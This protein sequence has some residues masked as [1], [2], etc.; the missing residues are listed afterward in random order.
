MGGPHQPDG[1]SEPAPSARDP[2]DHAVDAGAGRS[3]AARR[4]VFALAALI[5]GVVLAR[6]VRVEPA[7]AWFAGSCALAALAGA[8]RGGVCRVALLIATVLFGAG[9]FTHRVHEWS[10]ATL[11]V[12]LAGDEG[13]PRGSLA[14]GRLVTLEGVIVESARESAG[15]SGALAQFAW[16]EHELT[17]PL[18]V[19]RVMGRSASERVRG[20]VR[21]GVR[22]RELDGVGVGDRVRV[23]G[24]FRP[25]RPPMNPGEPARHLWAAQR[26]EAGWVDVPDARLIERVD[27]EPG[28]GAWM[29]RAWRRARGAARARAEGVLAG[30]ERGDALMRALVLGRRDPALEPT[31]EAFVR[32]GVAHLMAISGFHLAVMAGAAMAL[33]RVTGDRGR[34]EPVL[35]GAILL[36]YLLIVPSRAP[37]VRAGVMVLALLAGESAGRRH[38]R[39][40]L[41]AWIAA[42]LAVAR[43]MDVFTLGYQLSMGLTGVLLWAAPSALARLGGPAIRGLRPAASGFSGRNHPARIAGRGVASA[44]LVALICWTVS[45]PVIASHTGRVALLA[46]PATLIL[47]PLV[48]V[49]L[50]GGYAALLVGVMV[51]A[52]GRAASGVAGGLGEGVVESVHWMDGFAWSWVTLPRLSVA[53]AIAGSALTLAWWRFGRVRSVRWWGAGVVVAAWLGAHLV[54]VPGVNRQTLLRLDTLAVGD[55]SC[56]LIRSGDDAALFDCGSRW[57]GLGERVVP[58]AVRALGA[59]RVR[60]IVLSHPNLDHFSGV[61]DVVEP[62]GVERVIVGA[63]FFERARGDPEGAVAGLLEGLRARGVSVDPID[64]GAALDRIGHARVR[65]LSPEPGDA[66][67]RI[68]DTSLVLSLE[69]ATDAGPRGV[70]LT[71]DI[72]RDALRGLADERV[73]ADVLEVPHHGSYSPHAA[74]L[75]ERANPSVV[76]PSTGP[77]RLGE[78][79]WTSVREGRAWHVTARDGAAWAEIRRDGSVRSGSM[80]AGPAP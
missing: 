5:G 9:V 37:I 74:A 36:L 78:V 24:V 79:G 50:W 42:A 31:R 13:D 76:V 1:A 12:A 27:P 47:M 40:A 64:G 4:A 29:A 38:D 14:H 44:G 8:T 6:S 19:D 17:F 65:V 57:T 25:V 49:L 70:L 55:G 34:L 15:P 77:A 43:P 56:H 7:A 2:I 3:A 35:L 53:W 66:F 48:I 80:L 26:G 51:P 71:G 20:R 30:D 52:L 10:G 68:N 22:G 46:V 59:W 61:I 32:L 73:R 60:T 45:L 18:L 41:L 11:Q 28:P 33:V 62:L 67:E 21:V 75:V 63:S 39:V 72:Q 69:V 58:D 54:V 23:R 16:V